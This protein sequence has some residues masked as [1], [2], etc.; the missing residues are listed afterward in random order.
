MSLLQGSQTKKK[1]LVPGI[2]NLKGVQEIAKM[3]ENTVIALSYLQEL[4]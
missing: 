2:G 4:S 3:T 1:T